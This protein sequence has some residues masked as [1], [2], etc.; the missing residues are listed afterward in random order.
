[1]SASTPESTPTT[2]AAAPEPRR[3]AAPRGAVI[4]GK[5]IPP[6]PGRVVAQAASA[7]VQSRPATPATRPPTTTTPPVS[8]PELLRIESWPDP[9]VERFG[10]DPSSGY[11]EAFWLGV[12]GPSTTWLLRRLTQRLAAEPAGFDLDCVV[13]SHELGLGG[14]VGRNSVFMRSI[15]RC[16]RFGMAQRSGDAVFVRRRVPSLT[17]R[18]VERLPA[19]LRRLHDE[20]ESD[21][22]SHRGVASTSEVEPRER[23]RRLALTL[24][25]LGEDS[26][27]AERQLHEWHFH[28]AIVWQ[29]VQW[30]A[31]QR[32]A[33]REMQ[34][35]SGDDSAGTRRSPAP[36]AP[37]IPSAESTGEQ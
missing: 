25:E 15:D 16:C 12:L 31:A 29:A 36:D 28:P 33:A 14:N 9:I 8:R 10:H 35:L 22:N 1:M 13:L 3:S 21:A 19:R 34:P 6:P 2:V 5:R 30:A 26:D 27:V 32:D 23:A 20:W 18:Q 17:R 7:A 11:V 24:L 37:T 4:N